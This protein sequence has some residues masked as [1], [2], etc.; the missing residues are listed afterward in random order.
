MPIVGPSVDRRCMDHLVQVYNDRRI[1]SLICFCC[2]QVK[3]DTGKLR[4]PIQE[5]SGRWLYD[6]NPTTL[7]RNFCFKHFEQLYRKPGTPLAP[8]GSNTNPSDC[9][10]PDFS[11][12]TLS[13]HPETLEHLKLDSNNQ[14][15]TRQSQR[16]CTDKRLGEFLESKFYVALRMY[17]VLRDALIESSSAFIV[18]CPYVQTAR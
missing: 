18:D 3:T 8:R 12:W 17:G 4:S 5:V 9:Q 14:K 13:P 16:S 11:D 15:R 6:L 10:G 2:A 1:R 7:S